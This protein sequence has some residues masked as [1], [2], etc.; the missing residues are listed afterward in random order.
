M[1]ASVARRTLETAVATPAGDPFDAVLAGRYADAVQGAGPGLAAG[2]GPGPPVRQAALDYIRAHGRGGRVVGY[3]GDPA[4]RT[5]SSGPGNPQP[6]ELPGPAPRRGGQNLRS[7]SEA[8]G[9][10]RAASPPPS[11][12]LLRARPPFTPN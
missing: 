6:P 8:V 2:P 12:K 1:S 5:L 4:I 9:S 11:W 3:A 7:H 10:G